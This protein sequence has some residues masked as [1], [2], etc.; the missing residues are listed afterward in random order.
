LGSKKNL[1][2]ENVFDGNE[3]AFNLPYS[4]AGFARENS[5]HKP[6]KKKSQHKP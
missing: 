2:A 1:R 3:I 4:S 6:Q 5:Q